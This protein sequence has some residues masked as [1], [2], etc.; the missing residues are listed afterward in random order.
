[1]AQLSKHVSD[2]LKGIV[3]KLFCTH[4]NIPHITV[5]DVIQIFQH[6]RISRDG[7]SGQYF[8]AFF[9]DHFSQNK[10]FD[11]VLKFLKLHLFNS[12]IDGLHFFFRKEYNPH[13]KIFFLG[14]KIET[15]L[16]YLM[17]TF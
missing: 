14:I 15:C 11:D 9:L 3:L 4:E 13:D 17:S 7:I 12:S 16:Y 8:I 10:L 5:T 6:S 2:N 1:M